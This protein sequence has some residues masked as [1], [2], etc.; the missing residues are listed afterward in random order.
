MNWYLGSFKY[1][2]RRFES[3]W[4]EEPRISS[5]SEKY[6]LLK[7]CALDRITKRSLLWLTTSQTAHL[8]HKIF[9]SFFSKKFREIFQCRCFEKL[10]RVISSDLEAYPCLKR[11]FR[12]K[13]FTVEIQIRFWFFPFSGF[14]WLLCL[15]LPF[16]CSDRC[17][18]VFLFLLFSAKVKTA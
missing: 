1:S 12:W 9:F 2:W 4:C 15:F 8:L 17:V 16:V 6:L 18:L 5:P 10:T 13:K 3:L 14:F 7:F 11:K